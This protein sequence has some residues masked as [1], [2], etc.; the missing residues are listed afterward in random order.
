[1][2]CVPD[3]DLVEEQTIN[4]GFTLDASGEEIYPRQCSACHSSST[5]KAPSL[6]AMGGKSLSSV[7]FELFSGK[8]RSQA[9]VL[10]YSQTIKIAEF[11]ASC[12]DPFQPRSERFCKDAAVHTTVVFSGHRGFDDNNTAA[13]GRQISNVDSSNVAALKLKWV[14]ELPDTSDARSQPVVANDTLFVAAQ[15]GDVESNKS[16][17]I[18]PV[19][20]YEMIVAADP[21]YECCQSH[22]AVRRLDAARANNMDKASDGVVFAADAVYMQSGYSL[23]GELPGNILFAFGLSE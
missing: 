20:T 12:N 17:I 1:M 22:G 21:E 4:T 8:M 16:F 5:T 23:F 15:G 2:V 3:P 13:D 11:I 6:K 14:F 9:A 10:N 18:V 7:V 19:S